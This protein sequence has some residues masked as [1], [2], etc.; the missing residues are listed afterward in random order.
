MPVDSGVLLSGTLTRNA[1]NPML[2]NGQRNSDHAGQTPSNANSQ[3]DWTKA[4]PNCV[5]KAGPSDYRCWY[6]GV[7]DTNPDSSG[8][9]HTT[10]NYATSTNGTDW[11]KYT[12]NPVIQPSPALTA[13]LWEHNEYSVGTVLWD[14]DAAI[15]KHW[16]HGGNN[17]GPNQNCY[18]TSPDGITWTKSVSNPIIT[19]GGVGSWNEGGCS[20]ISVIRMSATDYRAWN[21]GRLVSNGAVAYGYWTSSDGIAWTAYASNPVCATNFISGQTLTGF[22]VALINGAFHMWLASAANGLYYSSST[23]GIAW[24]TPTQVLAVGTDTPLDSIS[25]YVDGTTVRVWYG[26]EN[27]LTPYQRDRREATLTTP[28]V[29]VQ[30]PLTGGMLWPNGTVG[31]SAWNSLANNASGLSGQIT[32]D[33][34]NGH[35]ASIKVTVQTGGVAPLANRHWEVW[36]QSAVNGGVS[37]GPTFPTTGGVFLGVVPAPTA[38]NTTAT[39]TFDT[40]GKLAILPETWCVMLV[41]RTGQATNA[42][43]NSCFVKM[44]RAG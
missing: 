13:P 34:Y 10:V 25:V 18:S 27:A 44:R 5:V 35:A 3:Y 21:R 42:A 26:Q 9:T 36:V 23:D 43:G 15:W 17:S 7:D 39:V 11:V 22:H 38:T 6:E 40:A 41:N 20:D 24:A 16:G 28:A 8:N 31:V 32:T 4:G 37:G 2:S 29:A 14:P 33:R 19:N 30:N 12:G 1:S